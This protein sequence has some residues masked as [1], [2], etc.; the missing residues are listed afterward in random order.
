MPRAKLA[1]G[2]AAPVA[3]A[4]GFVRLVAELD[5]PGDFPPAVLAEADQAA[6]D[7]RIP[8]LDRTDI[9]FISVDP[10][11]AT[12][13][14]Q[15]VHVLR[16]GSGYRIHYAIADLPSY[17]R[18]GGRVDEEAHRR[19]QTLYAPGRRFPLHP[20]VLA[21]GAASLLADGRARPAVL[22]RFDL[23][24]YGVV[25]AADVSRALVRN[26]AQLSYE[27]AQADLDA[28]RASEVVRLIADVGRARQDQEVI[29]GGVSLNLPEQVVEAGPDG[30]RLVFREP[31][32][33]EDWNA[34]ISLLTGA[35]AAQFMLDAGIGILRT[36]PGA[37]EAAIDRLRRV[38][39]SL[40]IDWPPAMG[41]PAFVRSLFPDEPGHLA[42]L[43]ACR[44][45]FRG[46]GYE[47]FTGGA[48]D[49]GVDHGALA[50]PYAHVTAP[51]RRL[52]DRYGAEVCLA[53][54]AGRPVPEWVEAGLDGLPA[55]M[56]SGRVRAVRLERGLID[57]MEAW[58]L[59][60]RVGQV[61][62]ATVIA[63]AGDK[64]TVQVAEPAIEATVHGPGLVWG[65]AIDVRV[66]EADPA[67]GRVRFEVA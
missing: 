31:L 34:Q 57:L 32:P 37:T 15:I 49:H 63:L 21:E 38:A 50:C 65:A 44:T 52:V 8:E 13:I 30:W 36:L 47:P 16:R 45:L 18:P 9:P 22:W 24:A 59:S 4:D 27:A 3:V 62:P 51:L 58:V 29:R 43:N 67:E 64:G 46:A 35:T 56:E 7:P 55:I 11:G 48:P 6:L 19:A 42:M 2:A 28:R 39:A 17:I 23:D 20:A 33:I 41:Y 66:V 25:Q 26:R 53:H 10:A 5:L 12:D 14:D 40:G 1:A 60:D 54:W 61:F